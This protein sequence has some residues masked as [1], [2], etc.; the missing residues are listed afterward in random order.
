MGYTGF[1]NNKGSA[2]NK[3]QKNV[4]ETS[5]NTAF[6]Q[7]LRALDTLEHID[8]VLAPMTPTPE[9]AVKTSRATGL[10]VDVVIEVYEMMIRLSQEL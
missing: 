5:E 6:E 2:M 3:N 7:A 8:L 1:N 10:P 4:I 9:M